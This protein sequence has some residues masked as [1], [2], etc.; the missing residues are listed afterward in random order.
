MT[1]H[2][3]P[4]RAAALLVTLLAA[5]A[6]SACTSAPV[7]GRRIAPLT[8]LLRLEAELTPQQVAMIEDNCGPF[9]MPVLD[10]EWPHG[11]TEL[12]VRE[13]YALEHSS[14]DKIPRWVCEHVTQA[15]VAGSV[16]RRDRFA[17]DPQL[18]GKPRSE[19]ADYRRSGFDRGHQ[20]PAGNQNSSQQR[21]DD[22]FFLSNM[23]PQTP[24]HNQ[25]IWADLEHL[26]RDWVRDGAIESEFIVTGGF[27]YDPAE[28]DPDTADGLIDYH[29]IGQ[30]AVAVP[31]HYYKIVYGQDAAGEWRAVAFVHENRAYPR[32]F[33]FA[34]HI[35]PIDWI[36]ERAGI[37][38]LPDLDP[39]LE[40][41]LEGQPGTL[42]TGQ[43]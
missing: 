22:T 43:E 1:K 8:S 40:V 35:Q 2:R 32:P 29:L 9:G 36:E 5:L 16:P 33:D 34:A 6:L 11:P 7:R 3:I 4:R 25:Q 10:P 21:K 37:D 30:G 41:R 15:E 24:A 31:T 42:F 20:A 23:T 38:F 28:E 26:T 39:A 13:G 19:L 17:P 12:V 18:D 27:F 14:E